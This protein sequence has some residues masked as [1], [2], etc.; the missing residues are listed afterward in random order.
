MKPQ[1][2]SCLLVKWHACIRKQSV[3]DCWWSWLAFYACLCWM[4]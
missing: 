1:H 3:G 2:L 4:L